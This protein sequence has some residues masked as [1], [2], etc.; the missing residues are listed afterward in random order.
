MLGLVVL[1][2]GVPSAWA[3]SSARAASRAV[4]TSSGAW[5]IVPT[6][7]ATAPASPGALTLS[8]TRP[9][10]GTV[11]PPQYFN[12]INNRTFAVTTATYTL[13]QSDTTMVA[14][15]ACSGTWNE[16]NGACSATTTVLAMTTT[17]TTAGSGTAT[18]AALAAGASRRLRVRPTQVS[19]NGVDTYTVGITVNR[20][21]ARART[22]THA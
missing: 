1:L 18:T 13:S 5:G 4:P 7:S 15:E 8:F 17:G 21:G 9:P 20:A 14:V 12:A 19:K 6:T 16:S 11:A 2:L 10:G 22:T 3:A